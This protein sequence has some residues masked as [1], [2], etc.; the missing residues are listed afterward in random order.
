MEQAKAEGRY[1]CGVQSYQMSELINHLAKVYP[2][3]N[4]QRYFLL[5]K[6]KDKFVWEVFTI[7]DIDRFIF[8]QVGGGRMWFSAF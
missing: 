4:I 2:C 1:I 5:S 8:S 3:S 6:Y 7:S